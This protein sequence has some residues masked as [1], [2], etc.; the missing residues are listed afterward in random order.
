M[1]PDLDNIITRSRALQA[2]REFFHSRDYVEVETPVR[3]PTP[4]LETYIDAPQSEE[5]W[6]RTSPELHMKRL[7]CA[8]HDKIFQIGPCFRTG[9]CGARHN[10]EFTLLEWYRL[11][12]D[13]IDILNE[14][15][16]LLT[17][18]FK[19]ITGSASFDY[20]DQKI[21][22]DDEWNILTVADAF[23]NSAGWNPVIDWDEERFEL[24]LMSKVEPALPKNIPCV[25]I[26]Y[27]APA[28]ALARLKPG[29]PLV[30]ERWELYIGGLEIANTYSELCDPKA[31]RKRFEECA[32]QRA[33]LGKE[34]Y[35]LDE[36]FLQALENGL[37][38]CSGIAMGIDRLI[39]LLCNAAS[40]QEV[41][42]F[43]QKPGEMF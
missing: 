1:Q 42:L 36:P 6:L 37:P 26:D 13:Y 30:A 10:P 2:V 9:E 22:L 16:E 41:R 17:H 38:P 12:A 33:A 31:Q 18:T 28:A 29:K 19:T 7:L 11:N 3:I 43:A 15:K 5:G 23:K 32:D 27:P 34:V 20:L 40:I 39:M 8:G 25:L 14:T 4:A 21:S 35:P 24:D